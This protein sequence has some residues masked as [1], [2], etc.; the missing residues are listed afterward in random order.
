MGKG[1]LHYSQNRSCVDFAELGDILVVQAQQVE[2]IGEALA[3]DAG[4]GFQLDLGLGAPGDTQTCCV[5]H[6]DI[7]GSVADGDGLG[8]GDVVL[9]G[10]GFEKGAL[11]GGIDDGFGIYQLSG[12]SLG[13]RVDLE[14]KKC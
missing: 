8:E 2:D 4:R 12:K 10:D 7:V 14:L 3:V 11:L 5:K 13:D 9:G 1:C 6:E